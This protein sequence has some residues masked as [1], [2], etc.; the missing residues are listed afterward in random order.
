MVFSLTKANDN[1]LAFRATSQK[2]VTR[3]SYSPDEVNSAVQHLL[4]DLKP[5]K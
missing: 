4:K 1:R 3:E 2:V 5:A